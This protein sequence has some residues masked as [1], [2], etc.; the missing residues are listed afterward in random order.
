MVVATVN[1]YLGEPCSER[2][3]MRPVIA[4]EREVRLRK[5]V[6]DNFFDLFALRKKPARHARDLAAMALKQLLERALVAGGG[7]GDQNIISRFQ[8]FHDCEWLRHKAVALYELARAFVFQPT[9]Y[10]AVNARPR[11]AT[12]SPAWT[13]GQI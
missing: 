5:T 13:N 6:L 9:R 3:G 8:S 1:C 2:G 4:A 12:S 10:R 7:G 11:L